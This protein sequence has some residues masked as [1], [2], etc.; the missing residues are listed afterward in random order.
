MT[1]TADGAAEGHTS[2]GVSASPH[3]SDTAAAPNRS[4]DQKW[5]TRASG[6]H[7]TD[8]KTYPVS[9]SACESSTVF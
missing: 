9:D 6:H 4:G 1:I 8:G 2:T 3:I 7:Y 5:C